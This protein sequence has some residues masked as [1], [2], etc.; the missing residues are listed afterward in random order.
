[1][2]SFLLSETL[3]Y[4]YLLFTN[5]ED[6]LINLQD[7]VFTTEAHILPL[8]LSNWNGSSSQNNVYESENLHDHSCPRTTKDDSMMSFAEKIRKRSRQTNADRSCPKTKEKQSFVKSKTTAPLLRAEQFIPGNKDH[9]LIL[10]AMGISV[11]KTDDGKVQLM[12]DASSA[13]NTEMASEGI[14]FMQSMIELA[15][16]R[17]NDAVEYLPRVV[18]I[19]SPPYDG[20]IVLN[21]GPAQFG[22]DLG[23][24]GMGVSAEI[25]LADPFKGCTELTN[26]EAA[27]HRIVVMERGDCMFIDKVRIAESLGAVGAIIIDNN[28]GS[29]SESQP[30]FAMSGDGSSNNINIPAVFLFHNE[31]QVLQKS[32][33]IAGYHGTR[34]NLRVR[35]ADKALKKD[36]NT[37]GA[38]PSTDA[39]QTAGKEKATAEQMPEL[40]QENNLHEP[41]SQPVES[42]KLDK[43]E[44]EV[45]KLIHLMKNVVKQPG[46]EFLTRN[47]Q[48][49]TKAS[50]MMGEINSADKRER[51]LYDVMMENWQEKEQL[52]ENGESKSGSVDEVVG[53]FQDGVFSIKARKVSSSQGE[54]CWSV[55]EGSEARKTSEAFLNTVVQPANTRDSEIF[56]VGNVGDRKLSGEDTV[57]DVNTLRQTVGENSHE[58]SGEHSESERSQHEVDKAA[59]SGEKMV[60]SDDSMD[61]NDAL[62]RD[63][64]HCDT[65]VDQGETA[66][67]HGEINQDEVDKAA[68]SREKM[69]SSDG[70]MD[71]NDALNRDTRHCDTSIDQG[72]TAQEH[73]EIN[74]DEVDKNAETVASSDSSMN[75]KDAVDKD[76][77]ITD[78]MYGDLTPDQGETS[79]EQGTQK[80]DDDTKNTISGDSLMNGN[81]V[82]KIVYFSDC[83]TGNPRVDGG[84]ILINGN[85]V[86]KIVYKYSGSKDDT[87]ATGDIRD[88]GEHDTTADLNSF[89]DTNENDGHVLLSETGNPDDKSQEGEGSESIG[90]GAE[91]DAERTFETITNDGAK[92]DSKQN[93][94]SG[95]NEEPGQD[96]FGNDT[97]Q[98]LYVET[99]KQESIS[100]EDKMLKQSESVSMKTDKKS[101]VRNIQD[102]NE[103]RDSEKLTENLDDRTSIEEQNQASIHDSV[104]QKDL[105]SENYLYNSNSEESQA[106]DVSPVTED[107]STLDEF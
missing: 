81:D 70:S 82:G 98:D 107:K 39:T 2:D 16:F 34:E 42:R 24:S 62:N 25:V 85:D 77:Y 30:M 8:A 79:H 66:Q 26:K 22:I 50:V 1:M 102:I 103:Q 21:A 86:G 72:E 92:E 4:L 7:F 51:W 40:Q 15:K 48:A 36:A 69:V 52:G 33:Q 97:S 12:Q 46:F 57:Y 76:V 65:S 90:E 28:E 37:K 91:Q 59:V 9:L 19:L 95:R 23:K 60:S 96:V 29:S 53:K 47:T 54:E 88:P 43:V 75:E 18:Q 61:V 3:K 64:R 94:D 32:I 49:N 10:K 41:I 89:E 31:G 101:E 35:L 78:S 5:K 93:V 11:T 68:V 55:K 99:D 87:Q 44:N 58:Q 83:M 105:N 13:D 67:E 38:L 20:N 63:T 106:P 74:Q 100:R 6:L 27:D 80:Y 17:S 104:I 14:T 73:G 56:V 84:D 71:V 45:N